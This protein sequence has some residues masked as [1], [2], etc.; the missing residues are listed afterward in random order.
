MAAEVREP[1]YPNDPGVGEFLDVLLA[2]L[3]RVLR[4]LAIG[5][6]PTHHREW[7]LVHLLAFIH[8]EAAQRGLH[9]ALLK[10]L[11]LFHENLVERA[12]PV[13]PPV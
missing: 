10:N 7:I 6:P 13:E 11:E 4:D 2:A 5:P 9:P 8:A 1:G 3:S 12:R